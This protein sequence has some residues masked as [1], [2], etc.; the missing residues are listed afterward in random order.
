MRLASAACGTVTFGYDLAGQRTSLTDPNG[1]ERT[2]AYDVGGRMI[3]ATDAE[4]RTTTYGFDDVSDMN[5]D[6]ISTILLD[7]GAMP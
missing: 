5:R 2:F 4:G 3:A 6:E 7:R 1:A